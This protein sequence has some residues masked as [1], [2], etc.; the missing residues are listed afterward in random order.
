MKRNRRIGLL[1]AAVLACACN[2]SANLEAPPPALLPD[3][4]TPDGLPP[5]TLNVP[6]SY[7]LTPIIEKL[8]QVVPHRFGDLDDREQLPSNRRVSY[9]FEAERDA[10]SVELE[11]NTAHLSSVIRYRGRGWYDPPIGPTV[12]A[13]CGTGES[14]PPRRVAV[15]M[16]ANI[17]LTREWTLQSHS[18]VDRIA[19]VSRTARDRCR[20]TIVRVDI[21][22]RLV[23][24]ARDL[25]QKNT[26]NIDAAIAGVDVHSQFEEWWN[27][28]QS[29]IELTDSVWL[30][31][32]PI[33]VRKGTARGSGLLLRVGV[34]LS[35]AP[36]IVIGQRPVVVPVPLPPLDTGSVDQGLHILVEGVVDYDVA[37]EVLTEQLRGRILEGAGQQIRIR[38]VEL[39]GIGAGKLALR[40]EFDGSVRGSMYLVGTPRF[41]PETKQVYVPDLDFDVASEDLRVRGLAWL[42]K[43]RALTFLRERARFPI[44]DPIQLGQRYLVEGLNRNLS[45]DVRLSGEVISVVPLDVHATK[46][47]LLLR[48][49]ARATARLIV[50]E[51]P[52]ITPPVAPPAD[53]ASRPAAPPATPPAQPQPG[54]AP[55]SR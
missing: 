44:G 55:A 18:R 22:D 15:A 6:I 2:R 11:G 12:S 42:A 4:E 7:D 46:R 19:P 32:N 37:S 36:R 16:S 29:P 50:R 17:D 23:G 20:I 5:S 34:G 10:F 35:A 13:S 8:E 21:T 28:L 53:S 3:S 14:D 33:A 31:I 25:L 40:V 54:A 27:V 24:A 52:E 51:K 48:A 39:S 45:D 41:D 47:V 1:T 43:D 49:H 26:R 9:A 30:L 38:N